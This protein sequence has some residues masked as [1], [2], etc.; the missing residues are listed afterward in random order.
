MPRS[1]QI[2]NGLALGSNTIL[3]AIKQRTVRVFSVSLDEQLPELHR[4]LLVTNQTAAGT[5]HAQDT[6]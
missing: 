3:L 4:K 2:K 1:S 5:A 6:V